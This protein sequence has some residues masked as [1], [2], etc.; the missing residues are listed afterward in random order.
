M[1]AQSCAQLIARYEREKNIRN[2]RRLVFTGVEDRDV[3]NITADFIWNQTH[4]ILGRVEKRANELSTVRVFERES[5][6]KYR[7]TMPQLTFQNFQDPFYTFIHGELI[8]GGVQIVCDP[9]CP[10]RIFSWHTLFYRGRNW[11]EMHLFAEGPSHMKDIRLVELKD[12]RVGVFTR[13]QG[14]KGGLGRIGYLE[15]ESL[16]DLNEDSILEA[17]IFDT[18]F[19]PEEWGGANEIHRLADGWLGVVG[20]IACRDAKGNL[21][22]QAMSF[23]FCPK[24]RRHGPLRILARRGDL[25]SGMEAKRA[26]LVDVLFTG[27]LVRHEDGSATLYTGVSDC[28]A[29]CAEIDDPFAKGE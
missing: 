13:P 21:H 2:A 19:L 28:M 12:G 23:R 6:G 3:Y 14:K 7:A 25:Y 20:H 17:Q 22:Y 10:E 18:H 27:G 4:Y 9:L 11:E 1:K 26:D 29:Y 16:E 15:L 24:T 5:E 8:L